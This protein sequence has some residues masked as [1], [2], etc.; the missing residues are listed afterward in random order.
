MSQIK[1]DTSI[2]YKPVIM[3]VAA[4]FVYGAAAPVSKILLNS[5]PPI[6]LAG[7]LYSGAGIGMLILGLISKRKKNIEG[8]HKEAN[9]EREDL[10]WVIGMIVLDVIAP[11]LLLLG[12]SRVSPANASL[13]FNFEIVTTAIVASVFFKENIGKRL[14]IAI[15]IITAASAILSFEDFTTFNFSVGSILVL[16]ACVAWGF[17]NNCTR[18]ISGKSPSQIVILKGIFAGST[19]LIIGLIVEKVIFLPGPIL[20]ALLTGFLG[21]GLSVYFYVRAQRDLGAARTSAYYAVAPFAGVFFSFLIY[22][23]GVDFK[24]FL[25]FA[26][27]TVGAYFAVT[28]T[29]KHKHLHKKIKHEHSHIHDDMHHEK[30]SHSENEKPNAGIAHSHIHIHEAGAH[31]HKHNPDIHHRHEHKGD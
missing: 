23:T 4:A 3:A 7:L 1:K 26:L 25:A 30:H 10:I 27:M 24:F 29:H 14:L 18:N 31:I 8:R 6:F 12:L 15:G 21:Y 9:L 28:E 19:S 2:L 13:L 11:I 22:R 20:A 17:E 16:G 5:L